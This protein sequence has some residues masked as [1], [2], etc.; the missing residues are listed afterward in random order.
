MYLFAQL[1]ILTFLA[2]SYLIDLDSWSILALLGSSPESLYRE[3]TECILNHL[4]AKS[5][6]GVSFAVSGGISCLY[7]I[8][9]HGILIPWVDGR[10]RDVFTSTFP[11]SQSLTYNGRTQDRRS[12]KKVK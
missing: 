7:L 12:E 1:E 8:Y 2:G 3:V 10:T 4:S 9:E 5:E 11:P 6:I